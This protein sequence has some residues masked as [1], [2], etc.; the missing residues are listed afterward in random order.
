MLFRELLRLL[1]R[2]FVFLNLVF[3]D[4]VDLALR[5]FTTKRPLAFTECQAHHPEHLHPLVCI[6]IIANSAPL[7]VDAISIYPAN[8]S[9]LLSR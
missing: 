1:A 9:Q 4:D 3:A 5:W 6:V 8:E 7:Y 2:C